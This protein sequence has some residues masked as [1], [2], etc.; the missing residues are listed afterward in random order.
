MVGGTPVSLQPE[1]G[2]WFIDQVN[3]P[4][5]VLRRRGQ[6]ANETS[7]VLSVG[8][9]GYIDGATFDTWQS[10]FTT[11]SLMLVKPGAANPFG[12]APIVP[13]PSAL[14][15]QGSGAGAAS[16][17]VASASTV[18]ELIAAQSE[19]A[20]VE[21]SLQLAAAALFAPDLTGNVRLYA[22]GGTSNLYIARLI[23]VGQLAG[24]VRVP[25]G[26][27][28]N[29]AYTGQATG[30]TAFNVSYSASSVAGGVF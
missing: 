6:S 9:A 17:A 5:I 4:S 12:A 13:A 18:V 11:T 28:V 21:W 10:S 22:S 25:S 3:S 24:R 23:D 27:A 26:Q 29:V 1:W 14:S 15:L 7:F 30:G 16:V 20:L 2:Y 19:D 8:S